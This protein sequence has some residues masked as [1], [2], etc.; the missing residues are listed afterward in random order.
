MR[1]L[2][3]GAQEM[4]SE[5]SGRSLFEG[6]VVE[7]A[8][9]TIIASVTA[10]GEETLVGL[11]R[12]NDAAAEPAL[13]EME[14]ILY[15]E[16]LTEIPQEATETLCCYNVANGAG[17]AIEALQG[18]AD[19]LCAT[20]DFKSVY[21]GVLEAVNAGDITETTLREAVGRILTRKAA[22]SQ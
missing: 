4:S 1:D 8:E 21:D 6:M 20:Q 12:S 5:I 2:L 10:G 17:E 18:G 22:L 19:M 14:H 11:I 16:T 15:V 7:L 3:R 13:A 9:A